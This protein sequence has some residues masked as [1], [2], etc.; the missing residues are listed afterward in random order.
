MEV[1]EPLPPYEEA[2]DNASDYPQL[3][4]IAISQPC[5]TRVFCVDDVDSVH[6]MA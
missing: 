2:A 4:T 6:R 1:K 5:A 3:A